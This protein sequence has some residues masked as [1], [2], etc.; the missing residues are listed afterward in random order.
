MTIEKYTF[1]IWEVMSKFVEYYALKRYS[2]GKKNTFDRNTFQNCTFEDKL[3]KYTL[4]KCS[5]QCS[6]SSHTQNRNF[7]QLTL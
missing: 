2:S 1:G 3:S 7:S 6:K 4:E 5:S